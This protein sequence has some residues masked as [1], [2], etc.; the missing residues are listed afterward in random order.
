MNQL[1]K[2]KMEAELARVFAARLDMEVRL[3]ELEEAIARIQK[4]V[5]VQLL[6]EKELKQ[7]LS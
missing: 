6:K 1:D 5:N 3:C 2:K 4:D 7:K